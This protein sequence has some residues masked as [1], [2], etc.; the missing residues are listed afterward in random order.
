MSNVAFLNTLY[1]PDIEQQYENEVLQ[2]EI[3]NFHQELS[4][5][6][7]Y[8]AAARRQSMAARLR[9]TIGIVKMVGDS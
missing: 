6:H 3:R 5:L 7:P 9:D 8:E 4:R 1:Q 2:A